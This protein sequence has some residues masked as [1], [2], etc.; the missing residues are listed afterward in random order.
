MRPL[1][2]TTA[3]VVA[4][5]APVSADAATSL[6]IKG[7]GFGH[8]VGMSQ[9]GAMGFAEHG[10]DHREILGHYY[11]GTQLGRLDRTPT[12]RVLIQSNQGSVRF[13][14]AARAGTRRLR[15][16]ST[17]SATAYGS[18]QVVLRS[19]SGRRLGR[20]AA[21]LRVTGPSGTP[22][23]VGGKGYRGALEL[24]PAQFGGVNAIN[25]LGLEDYVR[26]VVA[27]ESPSGW[28]LEALKAQAVAARTY[29]ITTSKNGAG[30]EHYP[31]TRSQMYG[32]VSAETA[33]TDRAVSATRGEVVTYD[34]KPVTTY[35]FSTSGGRTENVEFGFP[36]GDP[37][38]WLKSVDD[39]YDD[40]SPKHRW[41]KRMSL[42]AAAAKL[43]GLVKGSLREIRVTKR[44]VSPRIVSAEVVG[45][46]GRTTVSGPTLR[47]RFG[48]DDSWA[49]FSLVGTDADRDRSRDEEE[50]DVGASPAR[51]ASTRGGVISG[52]VRPARTGSAVAV[53]RR[54]SAGVWIVEARARVRRGGRY[55][56][57]VERAGLYRVVLGDVAGLPVRLR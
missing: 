33:S 53:Q 50:D 15:S 37:K 12:V 56:A 16:T 25:A 14:G 46:G 41:Q 51:A 48:L 35:F 13:T 28:P 11:S 49:Y 7:A 20:Y 30:W 5:A 9:Y 29:A 38:P 18:S 31:D 21:P 2:P 10:R 23:V 40:V 6:V 32:G 54:T 45:S 47:S 43:G 34:G 8:G 24:R 26:G 42:S 39:P 55:R 27:L 19:A 22:V 17:Y 1:L 52:F 3:V 36:G 44:G 57:A 4:L